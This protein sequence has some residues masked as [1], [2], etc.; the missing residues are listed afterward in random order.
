MLFFIHSYPGVQDIGC[1]L[2]EVEA[3]RALL[4]ELLGGRCCAPEKSMS[5]QAVSGAEARC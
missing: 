2:D 3:W 5:K 4:G 1:R